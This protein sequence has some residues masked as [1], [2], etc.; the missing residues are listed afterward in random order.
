MLAVLLLIPVYLVYTGIHSD[1][2]RLDARYQVVQQTVTAIG[3]P[4]PQKQALQE[5]LTQIQRAIALVEGAAADLAAQHT[6]WPAVMTVIGGYNPI[7]LT[8][9]TVQQADETITL[10][11][12]AVENT[13]VI[14]YSNRLEASGLFDSVI[15][16]SLEPIA[17]PFATPTG[18]PRPTATGTPTITP[19]PTPDPSD[20]Y[21]VDDFIP[22]P[23]Y[24]NQAQ[25]HNFYPIYDV[26]QVTFL[27]KAGRFYRVTTFDLAPGVDTS[28]TVTVLEETYTND[29]RRPGDLGSEVT[30]QAPANDVDVRI[31]VTNRRYYGPDK[32]YRIQV[33]EFVPTPTSTPTTTPTPS[34]TVPTSTPTNTLTPT[35]TETPSPT[36]PTD[37]P[38][39]SLT[40]TF[41]P[42]P[43]PTPTL[44]ATLTL[45]ST[46]TPEP[47]GSSRLPGLAAWLLN[48]PAAASADGDRAMAGVPPARGVR[49]VIVLELAQESP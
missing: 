40:P 13:V 14:A 37:T 23:I 6:D 22:K 21:E 34:P 4:D 24:L 32:Q 33:E 15:L 16:Q 43:T 42:T 9:D 47:T 39:P 3:T 31:R 7:Q 38:M 48:R 28:M 20:P 27:A 1:I 19:T 46:A 12:H 10:A 29:D 26:D 25:T 44:T 45:T 8:L 49:F 30:F 5:E 2:A 18:Q 11:G 36:S 17:T 35:P 41:T